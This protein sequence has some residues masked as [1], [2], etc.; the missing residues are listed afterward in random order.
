MM[1]G[2]GVGFLLVL[3]FSASFGYGNAKT[4]EVVGFG[5]CAD[6]KEINIKPSQALSGLK[7]TV[8]CKLE[9]GT[10]Q[11]RGVG[12]LNEEGQFKVNLPQEI[13]KDGK[14]SEECYV[15]LHNAANAPCAF[16]NGLEASKITFMSKS[17]EKHTFGPTG[18]LKFS[19]AICASA[20]FLPPFPKSHPWF[21]KFHHIFPHPPIVLP[22]IPYKK[23]CPP[24]EPK[25]EPPPEPKP[26]PPPEPK[27]KPPPEPKPKPPKPSPPKMK[28]P[29]KPEPKKP[30]PP[31][32]KPPPKPEPKKPC[33]PKIKPPP[34]PEPKKP[35]PP[36]LLPPPIPTYKP[37]PKIL[38]P[39][40]PTYKPHP[41]ILPP[42][43]DY[44][45]HPK[46]LPPIPVYKPHP[47]ILPPF[48][49][50]YKKPPCPPLSLPKL[51]PLPTL[52]PK[53]KHHPLIPAPPHP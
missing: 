31:K 19:S 15:Q 16:H 34:K 8:D 6:C 12:K 9:N 41:K 45:P 47:K 14:L 38:T 26:E 43:P 20:T 44:K 49:P 28:P 5:E 33:P 18:Q 53:F 40:I 11:T 13:L 51:P 21:K 2:F 17:D 42:I 32:I 29:P 46:I 27:P 48:P 3:C 30:C 36:K 1:R 50:V 7:V 23:P 52:P 22:P 10:F 25:P 37:H 35:C 4:V 24:P 39:P